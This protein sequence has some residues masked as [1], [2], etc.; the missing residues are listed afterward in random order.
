MARA[1]PDIDYVA[2]LQSLRDS[3]VVAYPRQRLHVIQQR[4]E[5]HHF[6]PNRLVTSVSAVEAYARCLA[7]R[8]RAK[9]RDDL[10]TLYPRYRDKGPKAL[11]AEYAK[12][13]GVDDL[14]TF[15]GEDNWKLFGYAVDYRNLITH[16]CTYLGLD[17]FPSLIE[18]C[19]AVLAKLEDLAN[20]RAK[21]T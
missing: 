13:K 21:R 17:V 18:A 2:R 6:G 3:Y 5:D 10:R 15:L 20:L 14:A 9:N 12:A 1:A 4:L 19:E 8:H 11:V 7:L 16:E